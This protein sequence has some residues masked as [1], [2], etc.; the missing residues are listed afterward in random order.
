MTISISK[1]KEKLKNY[2]IRRL[3]YDIRN[4]LRIRQIESFT[5]FLA[6]RP[7]AR[8]LE[9]SPG[10]NTYWKDRCNNYTTVDYP[11][12]DICKD[13]L[14][15]KFDVVIADQV[16]EHV[17]S[18][19]QACKNIYKMVDID[20]YAMIAAPFLFRIH[21]RPYDFQRWTE[22]GMRQLL[23]EGGFEDKD[24]QTFSWGNKACAKAHVGGPV[25]DYGWYRDLRN[26]PEYPL[27]VWAYAKKTKK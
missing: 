12:F 27:M 25:R 22:A 18:P 13:S 6:E 8:V 2:A 3:G 21:A 14:R 7:D 16:L 26:D 11:E 15:K 9:V 23:I 19:I 1:F 24:I 10:W 20:G 17:K 4:W 5:H